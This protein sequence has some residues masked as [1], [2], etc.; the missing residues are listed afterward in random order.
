MKI[1]FLSIIRNFSLIKIFLLFWTV[2]L[3]SSCA[4]HTQNHLPSLPTEV[5]GSYRTNHFIWFDLL[6]D[7][8]QTAQTFYS[9]LFGWTFSQDQ[10][11]KDY[12]TIS[13]GGT[14][15]GGMI[16]MGDQGLQPNESRWV[17]TLS[18]ED[19][20]QSAQLVKR[21]GGTIIGDPADAGGRGMMALIKDPEGAEVVIQRSLQGDPPRFERKAGNPVWIDLFT[22]DLNGSSSF[23]AAL[24]G[25]DLQQ[26]E[27]QDSHYSF[28]VDGKFRAG[29]VVIEWDDIVPNWLPFIGVSNL[30][31]TVKTAVAL[32]GTL[33]A[34]DE[35]AAV[36]LD[37]A[38]GALG[39]Q[40]L[41][42]GI[43][44]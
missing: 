11:V 20:E 19:V 22:R 12:H 31:A 33:M 5:P 27:N 32:G 16:D 13:N 44:N 42:K 21:Q 18:V 7:D 35:D 1:P 41:P 30:R 24:A 23:Y 6:T 26:F 9:T 15:I 4:Y 36:I 34:Y 43:K 17:S 8:L 28:T 38:G 37:P 14:P 3:L 40:L 29:V 2:T 39:L 25:F 10:R